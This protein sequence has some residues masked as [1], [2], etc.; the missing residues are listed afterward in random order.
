MTEAEGAQAQ[1]EMEEGRPIQ[2]EVILPPP[3]RRVR[4]KYRLTYRDRLP[5]ILPIMTF[6]H[7]EDSFLLATTVRTAEEDSCGLNDVMPQT[8]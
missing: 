4:A 2:E 1:E 5:N 6:G 7:P 8:A 3:L